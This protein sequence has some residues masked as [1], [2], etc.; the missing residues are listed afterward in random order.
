MKK[1]TA[2]SF[3][4]LLTIL[5]M[6]FGFR[7][8]PKDTLNGIIGTYFAKTSFFHGTL[9]EELTI[10]KDFSF[11]EKIISTDNGFKSKTTR[12]GSWMLK[13]DSVILLPLNVKTIKKTSHI[14]A[15]TTKSKQIVKCAQ[16]DSSTISCYSNT[17]VY[18]EDGLWT[19]EYPI[20]K[21]YFK[22]SE[23]KKKCDE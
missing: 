16:S 2:I 21:S 4:Y 12:T 18:K 10:K 22:K 17:Y 11:T 9:E 5:F 1:K 15:R 19:T 13:G 3:L 7:L 20:Y 6:L 23:F 14:K 8:P